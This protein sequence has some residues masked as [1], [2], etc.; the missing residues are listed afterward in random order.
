MLLRRESSLTSLQYV[1]VD[2]ITKQ[3]LQLGPGTLMAKLDIKSAYTNVPVNLD[4][5]PLLGMQWDGK[6]QCVYID[7]A[8]PFGLRSAP[9]VFNVVADAIEWIVNT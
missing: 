3:L 7:A 6:I 8:L 9:K 2:D 1:Q 4:N 5:C